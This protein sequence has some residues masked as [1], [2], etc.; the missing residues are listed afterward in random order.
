MKTKLNLPNSLWACLFFAAVVLMPVVNVYAEENA[1]SG[2]DSAS[3]PEDNGTCPDGAMVVPETMAMHCGLSCAD[4]QD[5]DKIDECLKKLALEDED[6]SLRKAIMQE[7]YD[8]AMMRALEF[9]FSSGDYE[10][11]MKK[12]LGESNDVQGGSPAAGGEAAAD[13]SDLSTRQNKNI[14]INARNI[15]SLT[16]LMTLYG[17]KIR[18]FTI[19]DFWQTTAMGIKQEA[20]EQEIEDQEREKRI[21]NLKKQAEAGE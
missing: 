10:D 13:G 15:V 19:E 14:K 8:D 6:G 2:S 1:A 17:I 11:T 20:V 16:T 5:A 9:K 4:G 3:Q 12:E 18:L 21:E 7:L